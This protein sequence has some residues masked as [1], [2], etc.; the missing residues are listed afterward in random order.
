MMAGSV[1]TRHTGGSVRT[2]EVGGVESL[3]TVKASVPH[4]PDVSV[5]MDE[6]S[7][8]MNLTI[9]IPDALDAALRAKARKHGVSESGYARQVLEQALGETTPRKRNPKKSAYGLLA[10]YGPGPSAEEIDENRRGMFRGF[11]EDIR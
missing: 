4:G 9:E 6:G 3:R 2:I 11:A 8:D 5:R 7:L 10:Q 1:I